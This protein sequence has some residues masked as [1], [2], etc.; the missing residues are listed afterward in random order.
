[1]TTLHLVQYSLEAFDTNPQITADIED[2][3][4][5]GADAIGFTEVTKKGHRD[6]LIAA[7]RRTGHLV[8]AGDGD[9]AVVI[10][11]HHTYIRGGSRLACTGGRDEYGAY[12][13]RY[14]DWAT[15][16]MYGETVTIM[17]SHWP[18]PKNAERRQKHA[19]VTEA[20]IKLMHAKSDAA[21]I[22]FLLGDINESDGPGTRGRAGAVL[23]NAGIQSVWDELSYWPPTGPG[24]GTIDLVASATRDGR[25]TPAGAYVWPLRNSDHHR[26]SAF[27]N[28][29]GVA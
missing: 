26:V 13:A 3:L 12:G 19:Q 10:P 11:R 4:A 29:R 28:V 14:I 16:N 9:T 7:A 22:A 20:A 24:G 25:V 21:H 17:E 1:M 5:L 15:A 6:E 8:Q 27:Y 2:T 18:R 23:A